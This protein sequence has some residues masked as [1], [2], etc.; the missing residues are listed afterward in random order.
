MHRLTRLSTAALAAALLSASGSAQPTPDQPW[1]VEGALASDDAQDADERRYDEHRIRLEAGRRY[2]IS[3]ASEDFDTL[4]ELYRADAPGPVAQDDDGGDGLNSRLTFT[5]EESDEY[6]LRILA[7]SD[8]G[9]G[10]YAARV[11]ALPP[12]PPPADVVPGQG[13]SAQGRIEAG[14]GDG[15]EASVAEHLLTLEAGRR[16][17]LSASSDDFDTLLQLF[18]GDE[19]EPVAQNDDFGGS[20][21]SRITYAPEETGVYSLRVQ[22]LAGDTGGAFSVAA[23]VLPPLPPPNTEPAARLSGTRWH[24]WEGELTD[25][26][27]DNDGAYF[28]D[29]L[30]PMRAGETRL[31]SVEATEFDAMVWVLRADAREGEPLDLDDDGGPGFNALLGF[32]AEDDGDHIVRVIAYGGGGDG[33]AYRLRISEPLTPP[34]AAPTDAP[35]EAPSD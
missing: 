30:V 7:F 24:I 25:S 17:R 4:I 22:P 3:A 31:I 11:E 16:Y 33:G 32:Q 23:E 18:Q 14:G 19:P 10:A 35:S 29:Y 1:T 5:P 34:L 2:R 13:W 15:G 12:L 8:G 21:N 27:P 26:D 6:R 28:D 20:L 9:A